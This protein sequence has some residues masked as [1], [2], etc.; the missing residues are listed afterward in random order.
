MVYKIKVESKS[1]L[2]PAAEHLPGM[3]KSGKN[4]PTLRRS[5]LFPAVS[6][7][8]VVCVRWLTQY[9]LGLGAVLRPPI[10]L[11]YVFL[12]VSN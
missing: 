3:S 12:R 10:A 4:S 7:D 8:G 1:A 11:C 2:M 6:T 5:S 9:F